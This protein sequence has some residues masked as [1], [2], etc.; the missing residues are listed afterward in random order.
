MKVFGYF[1][2]VAMLAFQGWA[3]ARPSEPH[4]M[5]KDMASMHVQM[6]NC[7]EAMSCCDE[8]G[9]STLG[10]S[11]KHSLDCQSGQ[12]GVLSLLLGKPQL[13]FSAVYSPAPYPLLLSTDSSNVWR[14]PQLG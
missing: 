11:C 6:Q 10:A 13:L 4:C 3:N 2:F 5:M 14:P 7:D 9:S 1:L 12:I 8:H